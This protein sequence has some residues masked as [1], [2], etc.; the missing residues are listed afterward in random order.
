MK[1]RRDARVWQLF[2][3]SLFVGISVWA[4][5]P[6]SFAERQT[7]TKPQ[8]VAADFGQWTFVGP[9]HLLSPI[10]P[11]SGRVTSIA[12]DPF[13]S[14]HWL[15]GGATGGVWDTADAGA[16]WRPVTDG[17]PSLAI[18]AIAFSPTSPGV[19]YVGTGEANFCSFCLAGAGMLRSNDSGSTWT[20]V[21]T[22]TFARA[23]VKAIL[24]DP[25]DAN[26]VVAATARGYAG[27]D[28]GP[29]VAPPIYGVQRSTDGGRS[30]TRTLTGQVSS[31]VRHPSDFSRQYAAIG[32]PSGTPT[33]NDDVETNPARQLQ[34]G[35]M[36]NGVYRTTDAGDHWAP[37]PGPWTSTDA[38]AFGAG[39]VTFAVAA[40][41]PEVMYASVQAPFVPGGPPAGFLGLFRTNN[42]WAATP[43]WMKIPTD[44]V[45][46]SQGVAYC[47]LCGY[48][49]V[50]SVDPADPETLFAG[51]R[52]VW[53]C[54]NCATSPTWLKVTGSGTGPQGD[55]HVDQHGFAWIGNRLITVNDGGVFSAVDRGVTW[56]PHNTGLPLVQFYG[57]A[58][59][60]T[61]SNLILGN[62]FD[63]LL[64]R[65]TGSPA[66]ER[67]ATSVAVSEGQVI[68][69]SSRPDS[70]WAVTHT[71]R[72]VARTTDGGRSFQEVQ[73]GIDVRAPY[74]GM[75]FMTTLRKCPA[76]DN[77]VFVG[78]ISLWRSDEFFSAPAPTWS[79]NGGVE[80]ASCGGTGRLV[81]LCG[82]ITAVA[83]PAA[84]A[85]NAYAFG[86]GGG[87]LRI[88]TNG[89]TSWS[90]LDPK[91]GVP[92]RAVTSIAFSPADPNVAYITLSSFD[93]WQPGRPGHVFKS[94]NALSSSPVWTNVTPAYT[95]IPFN[96]ILV[97]PATPNT[98]YAG[99]DNGMWASADAGTTWTYMGPD[100]GV[101]NVAV[102]D[103]Q[104]QEG[105]G[106]I[107]AFTFGR[108]VFVLTPP[109]SAA[110]LK[111]AQ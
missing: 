95:N 3:V 4:W 47:D 8:A 40:S 86:T 35:T 73:S 16:T 83:F 17:Q 15:I 106:K 68:M 37:V 109:R 104:L 105:T 69:S 91:D 111:G 92:A 34:P 99:A 22:P 61:R 102:F 57:G 50:L 60:P 52:D 21:N 89:G 28:L 12:I 71:F 62:T 14:T 36:P 38:T 64:N 29:V 45:R 44:P 18:G 24:V 97:D 32:D 63:N 41:N 55:V 10:T 42:A 56:R 20:V 74:P 93:E 82:R 13:N 9:T 87:F 48:A 84:D 33:R 98:I 43:E 31:L 110:A 54:R 107:F 65:F 75:P 30:W 26:V 100:A 11:Y 101:P 19:V 2:G 81:T 96:A 76:N 6:T 108:G 1:L 23:S 7:T 78:A 39:F 5:G 66:W 90:D 88:T 85:C 49:N 80:L 72:Y 103:L 46:T 70:D 27:R 58:V 53:R 25:S 79:N 67:M 51:T 77:V 59:H 94:T